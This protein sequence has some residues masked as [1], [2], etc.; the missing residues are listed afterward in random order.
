[1]AIN[2]NHITGFLVGMGAAGVGFYIYKK[3]QSKVDAWLRRQ[4][5][6]VQSAGGQDPGS[7]T[8]EELVAEKERYEDLIA[9]RRDPELL[10]R[11]EQ[12]KAACIVGVA[13]QRVF[14]YAPIFNVSKDYRIKMGL[15]AGTH[16]QM[17]EG[18]CGSLWTPV[19][20]SRQP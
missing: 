20:I 8:L 6:N 12:Q 19:A 2:S 4:G 17:L 15:M 9:E 18:G 16:E 14:L 5:I 10:A 13:P 11:I 7:M 1:M 3:N